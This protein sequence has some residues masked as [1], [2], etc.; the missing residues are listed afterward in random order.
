MGERFFRGDYSDATKN[1]SMS[2][3]RNRPDYIPSGEPMTN[4]AGERVD[5]LKYAEA[6]DVA[7]SGRGGLALYDFYQKTKKKDHRG[8]HGVSAGIL[9]T[10]LAHGK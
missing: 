10:R 2:P 9:R 1:T 5:N 3:V 7:R 6:L 8:K 4:K